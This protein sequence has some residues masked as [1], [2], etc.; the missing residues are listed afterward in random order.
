MSKSESHLKGLLFCG[1]MASCHL[2]V[3]LGEV[4]WA[5]GLSETG[6][7]VWYLGESRG[8]WEGS[9]EWF[10]RFLEHVLDLRNSVVFVLYSRGSMW[11]SAV[12]LK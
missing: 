6:G 12:S 2:L 4:R 9:P 1:F 8:S 7:M 3:G 11:L 10:R 5:E